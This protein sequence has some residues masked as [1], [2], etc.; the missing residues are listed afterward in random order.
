MRPLSRVLSRSMISRS[1]R[2]SPGM[3]GDSLSICED[4]AMDARGFR[5]SWASPAASSPTPASRSA[6]RT[7]SS[8]CFTGVR[9]WKITTLPITLPSASLRG[10]EENPRKISAPS[11][12]RKKSSGRGRRNSPRGS[13]S[14]SPART[15][16]M[17]FPLTS[18]PLTPKMP[19]AVSLMR[20][21]LPWMSAVRIPEGML[22]TTCLW[23]DSS[24]W[25]S[26]SRA[27][28]RSRVLRISSPRSP[29]RAPVRMNP[30]EF[31]RAGRR[32][33]AQ[34]RC[35]SSAPGGTST[36]RICRYMRAV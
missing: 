19:H 15:S 22:S 30:M 28:T 24:F 16:S 1:A 18:S 10:E 35:T 7:R 31:V 8:I 17:R 2:A 34:V 29:A 3:S 25:K 11:A 36:P 32:K 26:S 5:I 9:S 12:R 14:S 21:T 13:E 20:L 27:R 23:N 4:P 6:M 33:W